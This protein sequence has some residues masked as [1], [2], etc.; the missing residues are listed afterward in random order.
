[1]K[2]NVLILGFVLVC[3]LNYGQNQAS[4]LSFNTLDSLIFSAYNQGD[5][6]S[7]LSYAQTA[8]KKAAKERGTQDSIYLNHTVNLAYIYIELGELQLAENKLLEVEKIIIQTKGKNNPSFASNLAYLANFYNEAGDY[9]HAEAYYLASAQLNLKLSGKESDDYAK[10]ISGLGNLYYNLG[11]LKKA[12]PLYIEAKAIYAKTQGKESNHY[13]M[14]INNLALINLSLGNYTQAESL[15]KEAMSI[16]EKL[17]KATNYNNYVIQLNNLASLYTEMGNMEEAEKVQLKTLALKAER[18][19]KENSSYANSLNNL[20]ALYIQIKEYD[21]AEVLILQAKKI[22]VSIFGKDHPDYSTALYNL[23]TIYQKQGKYPEAVGAYSENISIDALNFGNKHPYYAKSLTNLASFYRFI[24]QLDS[25][26]VYI[27]KALNANSFVDFSGLSE[28][29][30]LDKHDFL[31]T[32]QVN[33]SI[34]SLLKLYKARFLETQDTLYIEKLF[35][36][37]KAILRLNA[38]SR[39]NFANENDKLRR[40]DADINYITE[41]IESALFLNNKSYLEEAFVFA[42]RGKAALLLDAAKNEF[43][44][45]FGE[46]PDS[47]VQKEK[48]LQIQLSALESKLLEKNQG[49]KQEQIHSELNQ[50]NEDIKQFQSF[51]ETNYP[52]YADLKFSP[53]RV[54]VQEIQHLLSEET[55]LIEYTLTDSALYTFYID[56][57]QYFVRKKIVD[58]DELDENIK[59][60]RLAISDYEYISKNPTENKREYIRLAHWFY[61]LTLAGIIPSKDKIKHLS[62]VLDGKLAHLPFEIFLKKMPLET[63]EYKDFHYLISDFKISYQYSAS[64]WKNNIAQK[65][66]KNN[67]QLF[68]VAANYNTS[69]GDNATTRSPLYNNLRNNLQDLPSARAE[70]EGLSK[71]F[72]GFFGLDHL[73]SESIFKEKAKEYGII[74]LAMHGILDKRSPLLSS[75]A[76]TEDGDSVENNFLQAYEISKMT[77]NA[78]LVVLSACETGFGKFE[79]GNGTASLARAFMYAGVPSLVVSLWQVNDASTSLIMQLFYENLAKGMDKAAALQQAKLSYLE[80]TEG[81]ASHPA[82]WAPFI[83]LGDSRPITVATKGPSSLLWWMIGGGIAVLG[84]TLLIMRRKKLE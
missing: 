44:N 67:G 31:S 17:D 74:H 77:L 9:A 12:E 76:F 45:N 39:H 3:S 59:R 50:L 1:M 58:V 61:E 24:G 46:L 57:N 64:L 52:K 20:A 25:A 13:G 79:R 80:K 22:Y 10:S 66:H 37:S 70:V 41:G 42:E 73:A 15:I 11:D 29:N 27:L 51:L 6:N 65:S 81:L 63:S 36:T 71:M 54:N 18:S 4:N 38:K 82:F 16:S 47:L 7:A 40:L 56:K 32:K 8:Q 68:A 69:M 72:K 83:Q 55:A 21:K 30:Q 62:F 75:L 2:I 28:L 78:D 26:E 60:L 14:M 19:G 23:A 53:L 33:K 49:E 43:A 5:F 48:R 34:A 35:Q 84:L